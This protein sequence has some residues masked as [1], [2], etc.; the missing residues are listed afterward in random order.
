MRLPSVRRLARELELA[1]NT[2]MHAYGQ[3]RAVGVLDASPRRGYYVADAPEVVS[4]TYY[5][6]QGL[7]DEAVR[8]A[9]DAGVAEDDFI[10]L[11]VQR[12]RRRAA[13]KR[14]VAVL[15]ERDAA[16][17]ERVRVVEEALADLSV[18]VLGLSV[19]E[20]GTA[21]GSRRA[22]GVDWFLVPLLECRRAA[23][24][25][26]PH[27]HRI[28]PMYRTLKPDVRAQIAGYPSTTRFG[29]VVTRRE[30]RAPV[31]AALRGVHPMV[32]VI[33]GSL[34]D[35]PSVS[36]AIEHGDVLLLSSSARAQLARMRHLP[37]PSVE[38]AYVP[39]E[40]TI[41]QLRSRLSDSVVLGLEE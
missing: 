20:L 13:R 9:E 25:L 36:R 19:E 6:F 33:S 37:S 34:D 12:F 31:L 32:N 22:A 5:E 21:A 40:A 1:P 15:G 28:V 18:D 17:G 10:E 26:G 3:L 38:L 7:L 8:A 39:N 35:P 30:F 16:L 14:I 11:V 2:V 4:P 23:M 27:A 29:L 24:L 41:R